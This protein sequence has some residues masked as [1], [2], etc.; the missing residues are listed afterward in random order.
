MRSAEST[1]Q[2]TVSG[3][4]IV[5]NQL[6]ADL[7]GFVER[8][9]P[10]AASRA[11]SSDVFAYFDHDSRKVLGRT[12]AKTLRLSEDDYGLKYEVDIPQYLAPMVREHI[13][14]GEIEGSSFSFYNT[15]DSWS[16]G[17]DDTLIR[18]LLSFEVL[19]VSPVFSPAYPQTSAA[20]RSARRHAAKGSLAADWL[21]VL[22]ALQKV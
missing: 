18:T 16:K 17:P 12:N 6:S 5:Y 11:L 1:G 21:R 22:D 8:I 14:R 2:V 15:Q 9:A 20:L 10:G 7:G 4:A 13:E 19:E 3:Y